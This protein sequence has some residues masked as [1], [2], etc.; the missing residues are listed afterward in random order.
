MTETKRSGPSVDANGATKHLVLLP[1]LDGTGKLF[2]DFL[3]ALPNS[4][5]ATVVAYPMDEFL[6]YAQ[7]RQHIAASVPNAQPFVLL[8]ES[9]ST[10]IAV[11]YAASIP[12]NLTALIISTGFVFNPIGHWSRWAKAI[13]QPRFFKLRVPRLILEHVLIGRGA[14]PALIHKLRQVL[15]L[16][17]P[18]VLSGRVRE[19]LNCDARN[20]LARIILPVLYVQA[21]RDRVLSKSCVREVKRIRP[22][23]SFALVDGPHMIL[24]REPQALAEIISKFVLDPRRQNRSSLR[25]AN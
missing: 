5:T 16:V 8:A 13:A 17:S 15:Q 6:S 10:P 19:A 4:F 14:P 3:A 7:L 12:P 20:D 1:G 2:A 22:D 18:A 23:I 11:E 25:P 24:Q 9:F 21:M